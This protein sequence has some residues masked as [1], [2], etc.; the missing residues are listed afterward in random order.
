MKVKLNRREFNLKKGDLILDN[1]A[2]YQLLTQTYHKSFNDY[3][4]I[5][6]KTLFKKLLKDGN[7]KLSKQKYKGMITCDL[8]EFVSEENLNESN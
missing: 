2:C 5:I 8:Y 6:S 1:G 3:Y 4:P 7:I